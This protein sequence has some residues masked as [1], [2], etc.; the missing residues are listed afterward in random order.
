M[1]RFHR[2]RRNKWLKNQFMS[3]RTSKARLLAICCCCRRHATAPTHHINRPC[4]RP[5]LFVLVRASLDEIVNTENEYPESGPQRHVET[6]MIC[7]ARHPRQSCPK[8]AVR[9]GQTNCNFRTPRQPKGPLHP[10][11]VPVHPWEMICVSNSMSGN[12]FTPPNHCLTCAASTRGMGVDFSVSI[13][14]SNWLPCTCK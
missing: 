1:P 9:N 8:C 10:P 3:T 2:F 7:H 12:S 6:R 11:R 4:E 5:L 13:I 14:R